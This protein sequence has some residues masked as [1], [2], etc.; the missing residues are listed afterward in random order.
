MHPR[1]SRLS[2]TLSNQIAAG[3]VVERPG[4]VLK[5]LIENSLDADTTSIRIQIKE[6]GVK[7]LE[8]ADDGY[9]I[10]PEDLALAFDRHA[11][12]KIQTKDDLFAIRSWGF[13]GEALASI[14]SVSRVH[15]TSLRGGEVKGREAIVDGGTIV[16]NREVA[17]PQGTT[18][19]VE[20]LFFNTPARRK[21]LKS[22]AA[23]TSYCMQVVQRL[24]LS[25]PH[26]SFELT[27]DGQKVYQFP[28]VTDPRERIAQVFREAFRVEVGATDLIYVE[29]VKPDAKLSAFLLPTRFN[30]PST[31]GIFTFVNQRA[32]KDR[33]LQQ[34]ITT[35]AQE[36]LFGQQYPQ[37]VLFLE[38]NPE[39][40][41]V[42]VHPAKSEV[43]FRNSSQVFGLIRA[44]LERA[45][46]AER[47]VVSASAHVIDELP[48]SAQTLFSTPTFFHQK[49][50]LVEPTQ[51][52]MSIPSAS[53][54][55]EPIRQ[56]GPQFLGVLKNTYL[57][58]QEETGLLLIDQ[59]A[60]HERVTYEKL[61][62]ANGM[63]WGSHPLLIPIQVEVP[64]TSIALLEPYFDKL[65]ALG[66]L[67][68]QSGPSQIAVREIPALLLDARGNPRVPLPNL[69]KTL[70]T[71]L[72]DEHS[73]DALASLLQKVLLETVAS[74]SCHG[75]VRAGQALSR[76]EAE[77]LIAQMT[78]TDF[79]GH[80]PH[81]RPTTV[82]LKWSEIERMFKRIV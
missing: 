48:T 3:E 73:P 14:G 55:P 54:T 27:I 47:P 11:T 16:E 69:V 57:V 43:R 23:E 63:N 82:R 66:L 45:L 49:A 18:V 60:A 80:C 78:D 19:R 29:N 76:L 35:A 38:T 44:S 77:A 15:L 72:E 22:Q 59:H 39:N 81:G 2:E 40:V 75:S 6:G 41:D 64:S 32:V 65:A 36:I 20:E 30:I 79:A 26:V 50:S 13:R 46:A 1:I 21:F 24:A 61:K 9:G 33:L 34:A 10:H 25:A 68:T 56:T 51:V 62:A 53:T 7:L 71:H 58:C 37:V 17:R 70:T 52:A 67:L 4:S 12:S 8:V 42:N 5:E 74:A 28:K 31:R